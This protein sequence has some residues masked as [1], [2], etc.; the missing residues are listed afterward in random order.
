M[1]KHLERLVKA[2]KKGNDWTDGEDTVS[3]SRTGQTAGAAYEKVRNAV[4]YEEE[5]LLRR[6]AIR[7]ILHRRRA[8]DEE[9]SSISRGEAVLTELIWAKYL[10]NKRVP[11]AKIGELDKI[12][13]KY[14]QL[15]DSLAEDDEGM[16]QYDWLLDVMSTEIE[17]AIDPPHS[18]EALAT[19]MF[20]H[21]RTEI[22]WSVDDKLDDQQKD[23][24]TYVAIHRAL[25]KSNLATLRYRVFM[26]Y[27]PKWGSAD[28]AL[29]HKVEERL[30]TIIGAVEE[31]IKHPYADQLYRLMRK[32]ALVFWSIEDVAKDR[33]N[34][35]L[36]ILADNDQLKREVT[37]AV[38]ARYTKF[39]TKLYRV[40]GRAV[41]FLFLTKML[42][43]IILEV[44]YDLYVLGALEIFPLAVNV[45]FHPLFLTLIGVTVRIPSKKNTKK[46][47]ELVTRVL[48]KQPGD[49][50]MN[51][52]F[53]VRRP[54]THGALGKFFTL[55]YGVTFLF[56]YG[57]IAWFLATILEFNV[58]SIILFLLFF[59]LVT[60]FGIKIRQS[61][62]ELL[63][64]ER[65]GGII[66]T[67]F[68]FFM[69]PVVRL[70]R[71]ITLR[72]RKINIFVF[73]L[74]FIIEAP[75]K[76]GIEMIEGWIAFIKDKK[77]EL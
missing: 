20:D 14:D 16:Y 40:V 25:L 73:F 68:D 19:L 11:A 62:R 47:I 7:R 42:L 52:V 49:Q 24:L 56:S 77:E 17:Y 2:V 45:A 3:V 33:P 5:H 69:L 55:F 61:V 39:R 38:S 58:L 46:V 22:V 30:S 36:E 54:W 10:P 8:A 37:K 34:E 51:V 60:F 27:F 75:F 18:R 13:D 48:N 63:V 23:M 28:T 50:S 64:I 71:W 53:N 29:I 31:Q 12:V 21:M 4:E 57:V 43:A 9:D 65:Q 70:G 35:A 32:Y 74:D 26:L 59:S 67:M 15:L 6:N 41:L 72:A 66:G 1:H 76:L 44:P